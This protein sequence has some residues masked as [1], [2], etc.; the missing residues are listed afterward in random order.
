MPP[1]VGRSAP[2][3]PKSAAGGADGSDAEDIDIL[4]LGDESETKGEAGSHETDNAPTIIVPE[5]FKGKDYYQVLGVSRDASDEDIN[6]AYKKMSLQYHPDRNRDRPSATEEFQYL[7][8]VHKT[9]S[10]SKV[11]R[12]LY[13][14]VSS[15]EGHTAKVCGEV[16]LGALRDGCPVAF[17]SPPHLTR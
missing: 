10:G 3:R 2:K 15:S 8:R 7:T 9:L 17:V 13:D 11:R 12:S 5:C 16:C 14:K 6:R 4:G 1:K